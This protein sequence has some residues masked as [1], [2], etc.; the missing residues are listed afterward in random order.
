MR[1][2]IYTILLA[3]ILM[4]GIISNSAVAEQ[5]NLCKQTSQDA[6]TACEYGVRDN[7]W[8]A[9]GK[10]DNLPTHSER[11]ACRRQALLDKKSGFDEMRG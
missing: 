6:L 10:C 4:V 3:T 8:L 2:K 9:I 7:Y 5:P 1:G 11:K